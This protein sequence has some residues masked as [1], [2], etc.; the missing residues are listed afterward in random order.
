MTPEVKAA[1]HRLKEAYKC[2]FDRKQ[3]R[4]IYSAVNTSEP[5]IDARVENDRSILSDAYLAALAAREGEQELFDEVV[6]FMGDAVNYANAHERM[7]YNLLAK[8]MEL[9]G[10]LAKA[11]GIPAK[12]QPQ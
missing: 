12:E 11:L 6:G 4:L 9:K 5:F 2:G 10:R 3:L 7:K 1:V 8:Y